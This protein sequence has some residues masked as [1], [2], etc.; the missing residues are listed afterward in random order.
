M[1]K[2]VI[3]WAALLCGSVSVCAQGMDTVARD[4]GYGG[5]R[6]FMPLRL[7][8]A[9]NSDATTDAD[10]AA[11][12][13]ST[14]E[15]S[16]FTANKVH[17]YLGLGSLLL[18]GAAI[19]AP[20]EGDEGNASGDSNSGAHHNLATGA[21]I[22]GAGAVLTGAVFH[23]DDLEFSRGLTDPDNQ[24]ALLATI[25]ALG[26][27]LAVSQAPEDSHAAYGIVG[28]ISMAAAIKITW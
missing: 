8:S 7:A 5:S 10:T 3:C 1:L 16:W 9:A 4:D 13:E 25:G 17:E 6:P 15:A 21:A 22:L 2:T 14:E 27:A 12:S 24:H 19:V 23:F 28:A 20:K 18:A 11:N 26:F